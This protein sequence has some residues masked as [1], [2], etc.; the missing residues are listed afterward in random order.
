MASR[1]CDTP[2]IGRGFGGIFDFSRLYFS[3]FGCERRQMPQQRLRPD[4]LAATLAQIR[5]LVD[6]AVEID[7]KAVTLSAEQQEADDAF[8][9]FRERVQAEIRADEHL[10]RR[11]GPAVLSPGQPE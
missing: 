2:A 1:S 4:D 8:R 9:R 10:R 11:S 5:A 7:P 6:G 3:S